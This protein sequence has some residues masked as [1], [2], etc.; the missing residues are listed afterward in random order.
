MPHI[1]PSGAH[2]NS[3]KRGELAYRGQASGHWPLIPKSFRA[4]QLVGYDPAAPSE[5]PTRVVPQALAEFR[6]VHQFVK[7]ADNSGLQI[8]E[9]GGRL[10]L[11]EEPHRIFNDPDWAYSWPQEEVL[12]TLALAQTS[13]PPWAERRR[14]DSPLTYW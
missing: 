4:G 14:L 5:A 8:T 12:E 11:Q 10:L 1:L 3:A 6:A 9:I 7:A 13:E 2:W